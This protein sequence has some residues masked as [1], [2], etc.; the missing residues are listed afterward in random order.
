MDS[1]R[2]EIPHLFSVNLWLW[3]RQ[4]MVCLI[5]GRRDFPR[6]HG[7]DERACVI[8]T[9]AESEYSWWSPP[10]ADSAQDSLSQADVTSWDRKQIFPSLSSEGFPHDAFKWS[11][12]AS[13]WDGVLHRGLDIIIAQLPVFLC[14][15]SCLCA[16]HCVFVFYYQNPK[17][18]GSPPLLT[19]F[20]LESNLRRHVSAL[21]W[22]TKNGRRKQLGAL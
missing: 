18:L 9:A 22:R 17:Q 20:G 13:K 21:R 4:K 6:G 2:L 11:E 19:V 5:Q 7:N 14:H 1:R 16:W 10:T 8:T 3:A 12:T 15:A